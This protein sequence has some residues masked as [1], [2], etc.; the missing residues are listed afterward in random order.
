MKIL[1]MAVFTGAVASIVPQPTPSNVL[2][3]SYNKQTALGKA[4]YCTDD[5]I[6][7][8]LTPDCVHVERDILSNQGKK[9]G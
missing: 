9:D 4:K 7:M 5:D 1:L 6:V 3:L 2:L 8:Q